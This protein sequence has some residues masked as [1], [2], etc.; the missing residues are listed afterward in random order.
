MQCEVA[1]GPF[2]L[3]QA[4]V[5]STIRGLNLISK[6]ALKRLIFYVGSVSGVGNIRCRIIP[7]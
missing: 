7:P 6:I 4:E 5:I 2:N 1:V 3:K